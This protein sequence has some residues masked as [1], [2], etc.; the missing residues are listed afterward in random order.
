MWIVKGLAL[1]SGFFIAGT[2]VYLLLT[3]FSPISGARATGST[4]I[5]GVTIHNPFFWLALV[6]CIMLGI[7][8]AASWPT[9]IP[10]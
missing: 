10:S 2:I 3:V 8:L 9:R 5:T 7:S 1:G 6:S 4:A